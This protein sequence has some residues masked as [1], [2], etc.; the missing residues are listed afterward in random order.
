MGSQ[1]PHSGDR[2]VG[3][4]T[5]YPILD[6]HLPPYREYIQVS[7]T[8]ALVAGENYCVEMYVSVADSVKYAS[9]N[10]GFHFRQVE[11]SSEEQ[12]GGISSGGL[13]LKLHPHLLISEVIQDSLEWVRVGGIFTPNEAFDVLIIGNF[14]NNEETDTVLRRNDQVNFYYQTAYYFIDDVLVEKYRPLSLTV[15]GNTFVCEGDS[16]AITAGGGLADIVWTTLEDTTT[17]VAKGEMLR[18]APAATT[19][20][21]VKGRSC[22]AFVKDTIVIEVSPKPLLLLEDDQLLCSGKSV[23]LRAEE[24]FVNYR[25]SNGESGQA[26]TVEQ[27]GVYFVQAAQDNGCAWKDTVV[28]HALPVPDFAFPKDKIFCNGTVLQGPPGEWTY[29]WSTGQD[30]REIEVARDG[31]YWLEIENA[32]GMDRDSVYV[33]SPDA[34]EMP[35]VITLNG[36]HL[37]DT[38]TWRNAGELDY[39][40]AFQVFNRWGKSIYFDQ[41]YQGDWPRPGD[42]IP[43]GVYYY[44]L[45]S[46]SACPIRKGWIQVIR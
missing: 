19:A 42:P 44:T 8:E 6:S 29:R 14:F 26:I 35:N 15:S 43:A 10:L 9:N 38:F 22:N 41:T 7:L 36:D 17:V 20:Y 3:L 27:P 21:R 24:G 39:A 11:K 18:I 30:D 33:F 16:T 4:F 31:L 40:P 1:L 2:F 46:D 45:R 13:Q 23:S 37:N 28:V 5:Y 34:L 25:W 12:D 32:C